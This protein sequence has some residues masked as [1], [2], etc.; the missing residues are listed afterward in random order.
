MCF[1]Q[2]N[3]SSDTYVFIDASNIQNCCLRTCGF[4]IDFERLIAYFQQK[5]PKLHSVYYYE[6][7]ANDDTEKQKSLDE[8]SKSGYIV[9]SLQRRAYVDKPVFKTFNCYKCGQVNTVQVLPR[10]KKLKSNVDVYLASEMLEIAF[11]TKTAHVV[12]V[13]CDGDYADAIRIAVRNNPKI[14]ITVLATPPSKDHKKNTLSVRL[15]KLRKELLYNYQLMNISDIKDS[16][17]AQ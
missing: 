9:H 12:L 3:L 11:T 15:K 7:I 5:Y 2:K 6:G 4:R 1:K 14:K 16:I 13:S 8:L 17:S 10:N